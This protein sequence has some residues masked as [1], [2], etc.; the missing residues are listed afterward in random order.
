MNVIVEDVD[1]IIDTHVCYR[2]VPLFPLLPPREIHSTRETKQ[3]LNTPLAN[4]GGEK[5]KPN[6]TW[7]AEQPAHAVCS[8]RS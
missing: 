1:R 4:E 3:K 2:S 6:V 7:K 5:L 8:V